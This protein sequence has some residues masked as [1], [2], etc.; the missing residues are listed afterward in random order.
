MH[1]T[2]GEP[3]RSSWLHPVILKRKADDLQMKCGFREETLKGLYSKKM[4]KVRIS[5]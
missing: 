3:K 5:R 1:E 2:F 4:K